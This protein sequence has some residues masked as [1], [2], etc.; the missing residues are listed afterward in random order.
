MYFLMI[1]PQSKKMREHQNMMKNL[2]VGDE[3]VTSGGMI[4]KVRSMA[5]AFVTLEFSPNNSAKVLRSN[6]TSMTKDLNKAEATPATPDTPKKKS[7]A[8]A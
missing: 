7:T 2:K 5:D 3:V 1:R 6:I 8:K 4:G